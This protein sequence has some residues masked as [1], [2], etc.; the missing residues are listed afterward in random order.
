MKILI[1]TPV[2]PYPPYA[3]S[4]IRNFNF[5]KYL[6]EKNEITLISFIESVEDEESIKKLSEYCSQIELVKREKRSKLRRFIR[7]LFFRM[8]DL[9]YYYYSKE[10]KKKILQ[11]VELYNFD[12]IQFESSR[13]GYYIADLEVNSLKILDQHN[14]EFLLTKRGAGRLKLSLLEKFAWSMEW[15]KLRQY[16]LSLCKKFDRC[17]AVSK[18]DM[19]ILEELIPDLKIDII[20]NGVDCEY[21][22]PSEEDGENLIFTGMMESTTNVDAVMFFCEEIFP[23][24]L[25]IYPQMKFYIVGKK[26]PD[27]VTRL[28]DGKNVFVTG[29]VKDVRPYISNSIIG[30]VPL[31][32]GSGTRIKI[33]EAMAMGKPVVTTALG[34][35]GLEVT[36]GKDIII[37][38]EPSL[39][40]NKVIQL[41]KDRDLRKQIGREARKLV[42]EKYDWKSI[43]ERLNMIYEEMM[44]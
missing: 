34:C 15:N 24:V 13:M 22:Y 42:K 30:V 29:W 33:L 41:I 38:D 28:A 4:D 19:K 31:R 44:M 5:I 10:M 40:A 1:L 11:L 2:F 25:K 9:N 32:I 18:L 3:G 35:E 43:I 14:V 7:L 20:P 6:S 12:I 36:N 21:F 39:F 16:E 23:L 17:L 27:I 26:P 8:P 37:A